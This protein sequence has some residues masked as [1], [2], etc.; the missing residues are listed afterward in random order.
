MRLVMSAVVGLAAVTLVGCS[1]SSSPSSP[2][3]AKASASTSPDASDQMPSNETAAT[4]WSVA[5]LD[6]HCG[7][8][9]SCVTADRALQKML[10]KRFSSDTASYVLQM[11]ITSS[12]VKTRTALA[13][14]A[15]D[16]AD[17]VME[18]SKKY[19]DV[20]SKGYN[21]CMAKI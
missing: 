17:Q 10:S 6:T 20:S 14:G 9:T 18:C 12:S 19:P 8:A 4:H 3:T 16:V 1:S 11:A 13:S 2:T 5:Y 21:D 7:S 15:H